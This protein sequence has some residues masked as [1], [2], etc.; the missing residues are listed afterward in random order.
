M[1]THLALFRQRALIIAVIAFVIV[2][3]LWNIPAFAPV[4]YPVR[5]FVTFVHETGH[6]VAALISGGQ[7]NEFRID[8]NGSGLALTTG[9]SR[10]LILPMGYLGAAL[11]GAV[12]FYVANRVPFPR[13]ISAVL[14]GLIVLVTLLYTSWFSTAWLV[15][16]GMAVVLILLWRFADR[17]IN[18][19][20]LNVLAMLTAL[21]AVLD[22]VSL[23]GSANLTMGMIRNDAAA[24]TS[25]ITP[26]IPP[27]I[28]ALL[29]AIVAVLMLLVSVYFAI[30]RRR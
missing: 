1:I 11:F 5:L 25:E 29:W 4:L 14:A 20:V 21:N 30:I 13:T 23:I 8:P 12:L 24:F 7:F 6:G 28:W 19:L 17:G 3:V 15:G 22:L 18:L 9:G 16:I 26:I 10:A 2:L 27:V